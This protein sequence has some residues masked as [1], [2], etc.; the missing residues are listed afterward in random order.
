MPS[1]PAQAGAPAGTGCAPRPCIRPHHHLERQRGVAGGVQGST[2]PSLPSKLGRSAPGALPR[3]LPIPPI[4]VGQSPGPAEG[5]PS[6]YPPL[7]L[8]HPCRPGAYVS[9]L[10]LPPSVS[11]LRSVG[12]LQGAAPVRGLP[13]LAG[14][15]RAPPPAV[16]LAC[17]Q[18]SLHP[19]PCNTGGED[20]RQALWRQGPKTR[21]GHCHRG[22]A[23]VEHGAPPPLLPAVGLASCSPSIHAAALL[24]PPAT[25][26][27]SCPRA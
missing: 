20:G 17:S 14:P 1:G 21:G 9:A 27:C 7:L 3:S 10:P 2:P 13:A 25:S 16:T 18:R 24:P 8:P 6:G 11:G 4:A 19:L 23:Q 12:R 22:Q 5:H 15:S 26:T